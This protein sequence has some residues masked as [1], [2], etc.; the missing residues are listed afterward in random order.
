METTTDS[1]ALAT[2]VERKLHVLTLLK[3][4]AEQQLALIEVG[5][6]ELLIKLLAAKQTLLTQLQN[7]ERQLDPFRAQDPETR[8]W[9]SAAARAACQR[10]A[11]LSAQILTELMQ[12]ERQG[13]S[14]MVRRRDSAAARLQTMHTAAEANHAYA[15]GPLDPVSGL[16]VCHEG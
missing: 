3:R 2:L 9:P 7:L 12:L 5:D 15:A 8:N 1:A 10:Q 13:E 16:D 4:L 6:M 11:D 14:Q